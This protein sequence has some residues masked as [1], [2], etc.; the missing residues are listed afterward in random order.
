MRR[1]ATLQVVSNPF[2]LCY[3]PFFVSS[4]QTAAVTRNIVRI[5]KYALVNMTEPKSALLLAPYDVRRAILLYLIP[6]NIHLFAAQGTL[7]MS[8]C[9]DTK[10]IGY[11]D[12]IGNDRKSSG[13]VMG[14]PVWAR[15]LDSSW[16]PPWRCEKGVL[17]AA[18]GA[19]CS[20]MLSLMCVCKQM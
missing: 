11:R 17:E 19:D 20:T 6:G 13:Q 2:W 1:W 18:P 7:Q 12:D 10:S 8:R 3:G 9:V 15:R 4:Q 14:N 5:A 16:G